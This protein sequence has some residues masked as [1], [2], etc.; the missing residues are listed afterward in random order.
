ML[1]S[2]HI[3]H[4]TYLGEHYV[5]TLQLAQGNMKPV[6]DIMVIEIHTNWK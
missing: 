5:N 3:K 6:G 4:L 1:P 2:P